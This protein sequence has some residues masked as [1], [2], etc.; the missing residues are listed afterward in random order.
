M[1]CYMNE[2]HR[3]KTSKNDCAPSEDSNHPSHPPS[4]IGS[5]S[6]SRNGRS[7]ATHL[8]HSEYSDQTAGMLR[9]I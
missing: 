1:R 6:A 4:L 7:L 5:L 3:D 9:L 2:P 8:V